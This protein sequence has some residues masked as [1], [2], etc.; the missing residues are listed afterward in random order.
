[1]RDEGRKTEANKVKQTKKAKQHTTVQHSILVQFFME[2][3]L[4][5]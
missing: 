1:M 5:G 4:T 2:I 3:I